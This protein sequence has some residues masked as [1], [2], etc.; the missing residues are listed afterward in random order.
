MTERSVSKLNVYFEEQIAM[1]RQR[2]NTLL[3]D[4]R[5]DEAVFEKVKA[6]VYGIFQ[7]ILSAAGNARGG[8]HEAV[9]QFFLEKA[10]SIQENWRTAY[11]KAE[12]HEDPVRMQIERIKMDTIREIK[13]SFLRIVGETP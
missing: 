10:E 11:E 7:T 2:S 12:K 9:R 13:A 8:D 4:E 1:C 5:A 6:N 3:A